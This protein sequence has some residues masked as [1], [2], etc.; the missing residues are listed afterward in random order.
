MVE[1]AKMVS[2]LVL[3]TMMEISVILS[4][5]KLSTLLLILSCNYVTIGLLVSIVC[6]FII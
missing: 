3:I 5:V 6:F 2:V 4:Q 1:H